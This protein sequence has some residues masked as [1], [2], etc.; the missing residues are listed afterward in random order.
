MYK[1]RIDVRDQRP[2]LRRTIGRIFD[3]D[4]HR[5][6]IGAEGYRLMYPAVPDVL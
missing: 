4:R 6:V 2:R 3:G 5:A 1:A